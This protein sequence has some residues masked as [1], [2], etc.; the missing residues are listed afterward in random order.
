MKEKMLK[1]I[2]KLFNEEIYDL[3]SFYRNIQSEIEKEN[4]ITLGKIIRERIT[5]SQ[6]FSINRVLMLGAVLNKAGF[7]FEEIIAI[8]CRHINQRIS[9]NQFNFAI[10]TLFNNV[11]PIPSDILFDLVEYT[12]L[13]NRIIEKRI[14][15][16]LDKIKPIINTRIIFFLFLLFL[17]ND[18][19]N[20]NIKLTHAVLNNILASQKN[21]LK[22][23]KIIQDYN[24]ISK[25]LL[26]KKIHKETVTSTPQK[27]QKKVTEHFIEINKEQSIDIDVNKEVKKITPEKLSELKKLMPK[28]LHFYIVIFVIVIIIL[29]AL[30]LIYKKEKDVKTQPPTIENLTEKKQILLSKPSEPE[31]DNMIQKNENILEYYTI[32][33][34][35]TLSDIS[36]KFYGKAYLYKNLADINKIENPDLI[37][38]GDSL[39]VPPDISKK[40]ITP[41]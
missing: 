19:R 38:P 7:S 9:L 24:I 34:G 10:F 26:H 12:Y 32:K 18:L 30:I 40:N 1:I 28:H 5:T 8:F 25:P 6:P 23:N 35:D 20:E 4:Q 16:L 11:F 36:K 37:Y 27:E 33:K 31:P 21:I 22:E 3:Y 17:R 15:E 2:D 14:E 39:K 41:E 13:D 29:T